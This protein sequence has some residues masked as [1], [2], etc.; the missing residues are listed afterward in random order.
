MRD[1]VE[2]TMDNLGRTLLKQFEKSPN[3]PALIGTKETLTY[4]ALSSRVADVEHALCE[5]GLRRSE[6][7][8]VLVGNEPRDVAS[9]IGVWIAN[10]VAV[11]VSQQAPP[12]A[13]AAIRGQ[14]GARFCVSAANSKLMTTL[15][16]EPPPDRPL[17]EG[18]ALIVL[19]SGSTGRPKGVVLS[20]TAFVG[21]LSA[22]DSVL[23]FNSNTSTL[24]V[25]QITFVFGLWVLLLTLLKGGAVWMHT[26]FDPIELLRSLKCERISDLALVPTMMRKL[27]SLEG[28][29]EANRVPRKYPLRILTGGEPLGREL[30]TRMRNFMPHADIA[31]VYG[32]TETCSSDFFLL[33]FEQQEFGGTIGH[34][35]PQVQFRVADEQN[36]KL[37]VNAIG[38]LQIRTP[39]IMNGYLD[40]PELTCAAFSN[41]FF[42]TG[43]LAR[44][45]E[46]GYVELVGRSKDLIVRGGT[47]ISPLELDHIM[48]E[49][50]AI[51]A[52]LT[53]GVPDAL[54]GERIHVLI[55]PRI[56]AAIDEHTLREWVARRVERFKWPD[57]YHFDTEL[58]TGRT[59][60]V[61]RNALRDRV[62]RQA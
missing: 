51:A 15:A 1:L 24:L 10:G 30:G 7:V 21:K 22:I 58:P 18:A 13:I 38:E 48:I 8:L 16:S 57:V 60:K 47:K 2:A 32:L 56:N 28:S 49:H 55:V 26:R 17:L 34:P 4:C 43:D 46:D 29:A 27:L 19:T 62:L 6:P 31:D 53:T 23:G 52:A 25:L 14:T 54:M 33:P 44:V 45:R 61:D 3:D 36:T 50:P 9:L 42:K 5:A 39:F 41:G 35:G 59:G 20:H 40:E 11:P 37:P 12:A